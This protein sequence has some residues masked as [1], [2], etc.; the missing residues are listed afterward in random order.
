MEVKTLF[1]CEY[2][3]GCLE[4]VDIQSIS[5]MVLKKYYA[6]K[7]MSKDVAHIR[8][9]DIRIEFNSDI[10]KLAVKLCQVWKEQMDGDIELCWNSTMKDTDPN[11]AAWAVVHGPGDTTNLH[12]HESSENYLDGAHVSAAFWI[13]APKNS[14]NF[15]FLYK[16]NPYINNLEEIEPA[17]GRFAMFDSTLPHYVTKNLTDDL[18]I[19]ISM[20]FKFKGE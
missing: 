12:T 10:Q 13:K 7:N 18:R 2:V 16:P 20:N 17:E 4:D 5:D 14:G 19:V 3:T 11:Q 6:K 15:V 8:H 9:E 1:K